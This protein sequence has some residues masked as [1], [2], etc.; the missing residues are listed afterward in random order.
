[1]VIAGIGIVAGGYQNPFTIG[2]TLN[3]E[4]IQPTFYAYM[5]G[6][7]VLFIIGA[8][9]QYHMRKKDNVYKHPYHNLR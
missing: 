8:V 4:P 1:M 3:G 9:V 6:N 5:V 7:V 2:S